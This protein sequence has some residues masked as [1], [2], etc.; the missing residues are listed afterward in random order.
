MKLSIQTGPLPEH[1]GFEA[2]QMI[3]DSGFEAIDWNIDHAWHYG[4]VRQSTTF[5]GL[6]IFE[7]P[8]EEILAAYG[9]ELAAIRAAGLSITQA[10]APF[11]AC[12]IGRQDIL[13]YAIRIYKRVIEFCAAVGCP[14]LIIHG[15]SY[16]CTEPTDTPWEDVRELSMHMYR[17][18]IPELL[19]TRHGETPVTVCLENLFTAHHIVGLTFRES[20]CSDPH[21]AVDMIDTLNQEAGAECFGFCLDTGHLHLLR[22]DFRVFIPIL[23]NRIK[24]LHIHDNN[25]N[26]DQHLLP[27][28]GTTCWPEFLRALRKI[29]Y[30]GDLSF[31]TFAQTAP[32]RLPDPLVPH[33]LQLNAA[34]AAYFK[35]EILQSERNSTI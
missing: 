22:K 19:E 11:P 8:L 21:D 31:E 6:T 32:S 24:A 12:E 1:F 13:E 27:Y 28:V 2:Y 25:Q 7:R 30:T 5:E 33:F 18:L 29:H 26:D 16:P 35:Q 17:S 23:G 20:V 34:I 4:E 15:V 9:S 10:H 3:R 14:R